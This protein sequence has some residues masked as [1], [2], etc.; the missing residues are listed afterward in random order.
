MKPAL[1]AALSIIML[2][3]SSQG[4]D[5]TRLYDYVNAETLRLEQQTVQNLNDFKTPEGRAK[6]QA[7]AFEMFGLSPM[8]E[9]TDLKPVIT[10]RVEDDSVVV[11]K[12]HFQSSPGL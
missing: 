10:G 12:I 4:A 8:P 7:E 6:R 3:S 5:S 1:S 9:R 11:E 2:G